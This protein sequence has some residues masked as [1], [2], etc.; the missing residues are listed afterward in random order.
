M[1]LKF[2]LILPALVALALC[3]TGILIFNREPSFSKASEPLRQNMDA[4]NNSDKNEK[5]TDLKCLTMEDKSLVKDA[6]ILRYENHTNPKGVKYRDVLVA[7]KIV[8][9]YETVYALQ[10]VDY[11]KGGCNAYYT[12]IEDGEESNPL[13]RVFTDEKAALKMKNPLKNVRDSTDLG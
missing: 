5:F 12:S 6:F 13:S 11:R 2:K 7:L 9:P 1:K 3:G 10:A 8:T 4:L